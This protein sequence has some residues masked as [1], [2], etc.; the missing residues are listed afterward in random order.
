MS[1][2][3]NPFVTEVVSVV[4]DAMTYVSI[5]EWS[6]RQRCELNGVL[7][8][9]SNGDNREGVK[10]ISLGTAKPIKEKEKEAD[11]EPFLSRF[12]NTPSCPL[13]TLRTYTIHYLL[14]HN[15]MSMSSICSAVIRDLKKA[16]QI[17]SPND[18]DRIKMLVVSLCKE[19]KSDCFNI[20]K[21]VVEGLQ[22]SSFAWTSREKKS[23]SKWVNDST[24]QKEKVQ[25]KPKRQKKVKASDTV[26]DN[27]SYVGTLLLEVLNIEL[28][29]TIP[30]HQLRYSESVLSP[31]LTEHMERNMKQF[32]EYRQKVE[33][34]EL[35]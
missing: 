28:Q 32:E 8:S 11:I 12:D 26:K 3:T 1:M 25:P 16:K 34:G 27:D 5:F 33:K 29:V 7:Q 13:S 14:L 4:P 35:R 23:L 17:V 18:Q 31:S 20:R 19:T 21:K 6:E 24:A 9:V 15:S 22:V 2:K 30:N 10:C